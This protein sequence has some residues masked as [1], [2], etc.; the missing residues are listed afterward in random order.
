M[1]TAT[2]N[3][4][5]MVDPDAPVVETQSLYPMVAG[6]TWTWDNLD[7]N[8]TVKFEEMATMSATT[9]DGQPAFLLIDGA[10][11]SGTNT[12]STLLRRGSRALRVH[13]EVKTGSTTEFLV[14]YTPGFTRVDDSWDTAG[15]SYNLNYLRVETDGAGGNR[16]EDT[17]V[18]D[19]EIIAI[20]AEVT[21][22][23]GT[24]TCVHIRRTRADQGG[25]MGVQVEAWYAP[26]VGKVKELREDRSEV[27]TSYSIPGGMQ[28]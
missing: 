25:S 4:T 16:K 8:G 5:S 28:G 27:L 12:E 18:H 9:F 23:A 17:R 21:V 20:D 3:D 1:G 10:G 26:G 22:P 15:E 11:G 2:D 13:K 7:L 24:F 14:D 6:A 19:F